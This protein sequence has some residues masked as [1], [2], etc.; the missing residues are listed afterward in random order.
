MALNNVP[1]G[2]YVNNETGEIHPIQEG[3]RIITPA[4]IARNKKYTEYVTEQNINNLTYKP[5]GNFVWSK[6]QLTKPYAEKLSGAT[7]TRLMFLATYMDY[8]GMLIEDSELGRG[9]AKTYLTKNDILKKLNIRKSAFY[10]FWAELEDNN[11]ITEHDGKYSLVSELFE[12]GALKKDK[13]SAMAK[14]DRYITRLYR[15]AIREMYNKS[16]VSAHKTLSYIFK[17]IPF[18]N[19]K[20]NVLCFNPLEEDFDKIQYMTVSDFC[21]QIGYNRSNATKLFHE[22][23]KPTF[24]TEKGERFA[25][26][27]VSGKDL[28]KGS[29]YIFVSPYVYYAKSE[30]ARCKIGDV[31]ELDEDKNNNKNKEETT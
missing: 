17:M 30:Y 4:E 9:N 10:A 31:L 1:N 11:L 25:V 28:R 7:I 27:Y 20:Y 12:I 23:Y 6:Y 26:R 5:Y 24:M 16:K 15:N 2:Y 29:F 19:R 13:L 18:V 8:E 14:N 3:S 21:E 22:L